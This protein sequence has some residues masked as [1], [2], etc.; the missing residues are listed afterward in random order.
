M[1][2][3]VVSPPLAIH[4][5]IERAGYGANW[6][7]HVCL[8]FISL[9]LALHTY[10]ARSGNCFPLIPHLSH[11]YSMRITSIPIVM[12]IPIAYLFARS[13][14]SSCIYPSLIPYP[15]HLSPYLS[16]TQELGWLTGHFLATLSNKIGHGTNLGRPFQGF[17]VPTKIL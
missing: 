7:I 11:A 4:V 9:P 17:R 15:W 8:T 5:C 16:Q 14:C 13:R 2:H 3:F 1:V 12:F 10:H 6:K